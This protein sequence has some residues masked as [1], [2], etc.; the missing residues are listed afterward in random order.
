MQAQRRAK[1]MVSEIMVLVLRNEDDCSTINRDGI[2]S[3]VAIF[4]LFLKLNFRS[5][6]PILINDTNFENLSFVSIYGLN[7]S[8]V[9]G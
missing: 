5:K 2:V 4:W 9:D 3:N 8:Y 6:L 1:K 7:L